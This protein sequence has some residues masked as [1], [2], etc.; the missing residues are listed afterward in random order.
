MLSSTE[1]KQMKFGK[2]VFGGYDMEAVDT[3]FRQISEDYEKLEQQNLELRS[4]M[5]VLVDKIEEYRRVEDGMR[6]ALLTAQ[7]IAEETMDKARQEAE[8]ILAD[9]NA[10]AETISRTANQQGS[11]ML[12]QYQESIVQEKNKL[13]EAQHECAYFIE[14][15]TR[16]F[17]EES[18]RIA[19]IPERLA[20]KLPDVSE[21]VS[22][23]ET[24]A[25]K[26]EAP[27]EPKYTAEE[28]AEAE[29]A[30]PET[31]PAEESETSFS[32]E[33]SGSA[34]E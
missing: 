4:K 11:L 26:V 13:R 1:V 22:R 3:A 9:A 27:I 25:G 33:V 24:L 8:R 12:H 14:L 17:K 19:S 20:F 18:E 15:M 2:A 32:V 30:P 10:Q 7:N 16:R 31:E 23:A 5:K 29:S 6:Q 28:E 34:A 21:E